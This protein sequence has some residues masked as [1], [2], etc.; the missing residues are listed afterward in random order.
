MSISYSGITSYGKATLPSVESWGTNMNILRDPPRSITTRRIDKV[1]QT[2]SITEMIDESENRAAEMIK[3]FARGVNPFVSVSYD[4]NSNNGGQGSNSMYNK[5]ASLPYK[6]SADAFRPPIVTQENLLPLSRLPRVWTTAFTQ[7]GFADFSKKMRTCGTA[8]D[9]REVKNQILSASVRPTAVY[10]L[11]TPLSAP[12]DTKDKIQ[13]IFNVS[14]TPNMSSTDQTVLSVMTPTGQV[15]TDNIHTWA[16]SNVSDNTKY[17]DNNTYDNAYNFIQDTHNMEAYTN[18]GSDAIQNVAFSDVD[19]SNLKMQD[20]LYT[21]YTTPTVGVSQV[22][23]LHDDLV[24]SKV[25]PSHSA[26]SNVVGRVMKENR[27]H[28]DI[29]LSRNVPLHNIYSQKTGNEKV[30]YIHKN[31]SLDRVLPEHQAGT[32]LKHNQQ[33]IINPEYVR[34]QERNLP[35]V[36]IN[37][38]KNYTGNYNRTNTQYKATE[39]LNLGGYS[40]PAG[41][42]QIN[43][44]QGIPSLGD[45]NRSQMNTNIRENYQRYQRI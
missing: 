39:S 24:L 29:S 42:P 8:E 32:N 23:Y 19:I 16:Q 4:N 21:D 6:I 44:E 20:V 34:E 10:R 26:N 36:D 11:E 3:P 30:D 35:H 1:G 27:I 40:I 28:D 12:S 25:L 7:P 45:S 43:R 9:T 14:Y 33:R 17:V 15:Y 22:N 18:I 41:I 31:I 38:N 2:S 5:Q 13:P 37:L